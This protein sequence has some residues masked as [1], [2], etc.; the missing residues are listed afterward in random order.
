MCPKRVKYLILFFTTFHLEQLKSSY[1]CDIFHER[2]NSYADLSAC[3]D[4]GSTYNTREKCLQICN[5]M[6]NCSAVVFDSSYTFFN[7]C[8]LLQR[9]GPLLAGPGLITL[10]NKRTTEHGRSG[11]N[12]PCGSQWTAPSGWNI[13]GPVTHVDFTNTTCIQTFNGATVVSHTMQKCLNILCG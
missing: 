10:Y 2:K 9:D 4:P 12:N 8:C 7:G 3:I 13:T 11:V 5:D 6:S 1:S